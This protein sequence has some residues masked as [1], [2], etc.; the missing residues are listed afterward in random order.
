M[1]RVEVTMGGLN[2][3]NCAGMIEEKVKAR[4]EIDRAN[5]KI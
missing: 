1:T 5:L 4:K 2:C 3:A